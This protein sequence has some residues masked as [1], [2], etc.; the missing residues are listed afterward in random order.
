MRAGRP[1]LITLIGAIPLLFIVYLM[2][3]KPY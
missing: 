3:M 2:V 1:G